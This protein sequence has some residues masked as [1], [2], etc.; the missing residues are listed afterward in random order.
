MSKHKKFGLALIFLA[1]HGAA[2]SGAYVGIAGGEGWSNATSKLYDFYD[3]GHYGLTRKDNNRPAYALYLGDTLSERDALELSYTNFGQYK[4]T[5]PTFGDST[6]ASAFSFRWVHQF[7]IN[8]KSGVDS[9][10]GAAWMKEQYHCLS[11]CAGLPDT[12]TNRLVGVA[13]VGVYWGIS[14]AVRIRAGVDYYNG[15]RFTIR[16]QGADYQLSANYLVA[17]LGVEYHF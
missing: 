4:I 13:G 12:T 2:F 6:R 9:H 5:S 7:P 17:A 10:L 1:C 8:E 15:G 11:E 16:D 14:P 3:Y